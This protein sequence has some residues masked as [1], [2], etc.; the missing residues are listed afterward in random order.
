MFTQTESYSK[1]SDDEEK[2]SNEKEKSSANEEKSSKEEEKSSDKKKNPVVLT[3]HRGKKKN[4]TPSKKK[5]QHPTSKYKENS[6][7]FQNP[8]V[9]KKMRHTTLTPPQRYMKKTPKI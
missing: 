3:S 9:T 5:I 4:V 7:P 1:L 2:P 8:L 6:L